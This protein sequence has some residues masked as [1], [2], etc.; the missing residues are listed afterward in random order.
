[1][2]MVDLPSSIVLLV[3]DPRVSILPRLPKVEVCHSALD[4]CSFFISPCWSR[5]DV[6]SITEGFNFAENMRA[7]AERSSISGPGMANG[8]GS[9]GTHSKAKSISVMEPPVKEMPPQPRKPDQF[10]ERILKGDFY[11]D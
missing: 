9:P 1:M 7:R 3:I 4:H 11:M 5:A 10:Q 6:S 8:S 2:P